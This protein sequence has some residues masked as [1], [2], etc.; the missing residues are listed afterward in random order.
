MSPTLPALGHSHLSGHEALL[1]F[2][3]TSPTHQYTQEEFGG[4]GPVIH[5]QAANERG[6]LQR[7]GDHVLHGEEVMLEDPSVAQEAQFPVL[8]H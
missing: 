6:H 3:P 1:L 7:A 2:S 8:L 4:Q 5:A